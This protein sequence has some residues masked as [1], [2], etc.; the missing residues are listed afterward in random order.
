MEPLGA[1]VIGHNRPAVSTECAISR[2]TDAGYLQ[3][4]ASGGEIGEAPLGAAKREAR[5]ELKSRLP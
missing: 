2:T 5:K 3:E 1:L 4:I